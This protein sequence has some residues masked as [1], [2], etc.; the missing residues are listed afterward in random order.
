MHDW[1]IGIIKA[2]DKF[3][4]KAPFHAVQKVEGLIILKQFFF[5]ENKYRKNTLRL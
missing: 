3:A 4:G 5:T 1:E 2:L